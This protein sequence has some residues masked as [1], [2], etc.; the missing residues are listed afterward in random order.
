MKFDQKAFQYHEKASIQKKVADWFSQWIDKDCSRLAGLEL[1]AG[2]GLFTR[3]LAVRSF[4]E[5]CATDISQSMLHEGKVRLPNICWEI[6][7]AWRLEARKADRVY[8]CSLLQWAND[9]IRVLSIWR[10]ALLENG[11]LLVCFFIE[12]SLEEFTRLD[13]RFPAFP[14]KGEKEWVEIFRAA[15]LDIV[16]SETRT[17]I[18]TYESPRAALRQIHDIGAISENRMKPSVLKR[19]LEDLEKREKGYFEL[20]WR[21]MRVECLHSNQCL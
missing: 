11:R 3:H 16:R 13:S 2:T 6:Q 7:D 10:D 15:N 14:W 1:G 18:M 19:L 4:R 12:G 8:A 21:T 17:D 20:S 9:P 5:F